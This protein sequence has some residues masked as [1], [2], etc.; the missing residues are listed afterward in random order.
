MRASAEAGPAEPGATPQLDVHVRRGPVD[1][2]LTV[3]LDGVTVLFGPS[4][5]GKTTLLRAVAGLGEGDGVEVRFG[6]EQWDG[7]RRRTP[8]R[9]R[10]TG[11][12]TQAPGLFPHL[13]VRDNVAFGLHGPTWAGSRLR[14]TAR[15]DRTDGVPHADPDRRALECLGLVGAEHLA[16]RRVTTLSGGEA[17]R[18]ALARAL[19]PRPRLLLLDEPLSGLDGPAREAL[20]TDLRSL[21][22]AE[23][24]PTLLVTHDRTEALALADRVA[25]VVAGSVR[26]VGPPTAVFDRPADPDVAGVVGVETVADGVVTGAADGLVRV[27]AGG[28]ELTALAERALVA[29]T[30]V[31]VCVRAQDVVLERSPGPSSARNHLVGVVRTVTPQGALVRVDVRCGESFDLAAYVTRPAV[32]ELGLRPGVA[33]AAAVKAPAVHLVERPGPVRPAPP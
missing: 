31:L 15:T 28:A 1:A 7:A 27:R 8:A 23:G 17:Q 13:D 16:D 20:R 18:V 14:R 19:A 21:L 32:D 24:V 2:R 30:H 29:G 33:V 10:R 12:V 22:V 6:G 26:Q 9:A 25:V 11:Y 5:A 4:G 3:P